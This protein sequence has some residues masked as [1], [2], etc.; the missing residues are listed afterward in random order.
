MKK[1]YITSGLFALI[2]V[3]AGISPDSLQ[4]R[5]NGSNITANYSGISGTTCNTSGCHTG[6]LNSGPGGVAITTDIPV[7]GYVGGTT[8]NV[9]VTVTAGGTN[10]AAFG[11]CCSAAK[12]GTSTTTGGFAA[13]DNTTLIKSGGIYIVHNVAATGGGINSSHTFTFNW[14]APAA[15]TGAV[16]FFVAG[17]SA[18]GNSAD[19]GDQIYNSSS[20]V[21]EAPGAGFTESVLKAFNLFPNPATEYVTVNVPTQLMDGTVRVLDITGK[22]VFNTQLTNTNVTIDLGQ[23][24]QGAYIVEIQ[25]DGQSYTSK[26]L[27]N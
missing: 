2:F 10:G 4:A 14:T 19:T 18:N 12:N 16:K 7:N 9:N 3:G 26:L 6:T 8:Y 5:I 11:F 13:P 17:N 24:M 21:E 25:K 22:T 23:F 1:F 20:V 15:G 27:K